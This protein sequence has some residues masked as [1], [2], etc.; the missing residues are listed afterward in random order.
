[1]K[2]R[3][4]DEFC[5]LNIMIVVEVNE[6]EDVW[7]L[8]FSFCWQFYRFW[9]QLYQVDICWK[10][11][12]YECQY[13]ILVE[14]MVELRFQEDLYIFKD[15]QVVGMIIIGVVKYC[16]I[17]QKVELR[18]VIVEE[19]VEVFEVYII[20]ILSKVCQYFILIGDY[21]QLCF[22]VN[23]YDLVKNF[24]FEVFFFEWLVKVNI[25]FVCLNYQYCMCFEIVCFLI[26]YIYQDLENY[27]F[28]FK[29]EKIK[30]VFF[31]FFFVEYNFF[32]QEI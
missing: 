24:N 11:F 6:I 31:N 3:V 4:K 5:K 12:S 21:Q 8:D 7:Y 20:V 28:V 22:S 25:F 29:Y 9:L 15:V 27:L 16:Q 14:R 30:G 17:L 2:K 32:E 1:M 18:I 19:V 10:I 23:V 13:C 26:F